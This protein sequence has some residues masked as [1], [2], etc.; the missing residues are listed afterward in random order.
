MIGLLVLVVATD[1]LLHTHLVGGFSSDFVCPVVESAE[2]AVLHMRS[3][4]LIYL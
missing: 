3:N 4:S 2:I 1:P